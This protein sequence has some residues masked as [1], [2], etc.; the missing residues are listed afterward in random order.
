MVMHSMQ[1]V[2]FRIT[3]FQFARDRV[4]GDSQV[5]ADEVNVAAIELI[6]KQGNVGLGFLQ[7]L[8]F[9]LPSEDELIRVFRAEA[10]PGLEGQNAG[11]LAHRVTRSR[12]GNTRRMSVSFEEALQQAIWDL[13]AKGVNQPL[14][15]LLGGR[16]RSVRAYASGLDFHLADTEFQALF[17]AA[18]E[19]GFTAFKIKVGHPDVERDIH[20]LNLLNEAVG[21]VLASET[22]NPPRV[23]I[24]ANEAWTAKQTIRNLELF[25]RAGHQI[26]WVEDPVLRTDIDGLRLLR[27]TAGPT[28]INSGEYLD[29][30]DKRLLM[31]ANAT[32]MLNVH[33]HVTDVMRIGWLAADMGVPVTLGNSFLEVGVNMALALPEVEWVEYSYQNFEHLVERPFEIRDGLIYGSD[34]PGHGLVLSET[35]RQQ[36]RRPQILDRTAL[37]QAPPQCRLHKA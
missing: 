32:D 14:W 23:M 27:N 11:A 25:R 34:A 33:G 37:G 3:R 36:W 35:A 6:D 30:S 16:R 21:H 5:R 24:D 8:F 29:A 1:I 19:E 13:F 7:S 17:R 31:Q 10:W 9:A 20:R 15:A 22:D 4:I 26:F 18:A 12:G 2:D 28:L